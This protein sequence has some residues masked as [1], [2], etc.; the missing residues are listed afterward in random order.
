M[1]IYVTGD[2]HGNFRRLGRKYFP[3]Q[4]NMTRNDCVIIC[5]DFGGLWDSSEAE[6]YWLDWLNDKPWTTLW[7]DGNHENYTLLSGFPLEIWYGGMAQRI[8]PNIM[9]LMR[10]YVF[11]LQGYTF[12]T[13]GGAKSHDMEDGILDPK[14]PDFETQLIMFQIRG[15]RYRV[16][17]QSWWP[18]ELPSEEEY[19]KARH[20][21]EEHDWAVD[22][23][24]THC[25]PTGV[26]QAINSHNEADLL[27]DFLQEI[28]KRVMYHYWLFGHY[29]RNQVIDD[30][31]ILLWEQIVQI[32]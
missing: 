27:T 10:G 11:E 26:A 5:G 16:L 9:H 3:E 13:M 28:Q 30:R 25:A 17:G 14:A 18:E 20:S 15:R 32:I 31:H 23:I 8:R 24:I 1:S 6:N 19:T 12:F 4:T 7:V 22:Y 2:C 21:L 29:H